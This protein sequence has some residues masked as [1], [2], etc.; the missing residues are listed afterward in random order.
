[1]KK[2]LLILFTLV[3]FSI[4]TK[5]QFGNTLILNGSNV[6]TRQTSEGG[7]WIKKLIQPPTFSDTTAANNG[8]T[9]FYAGSIIF[10][11]N[12]NGFWYR[13]ATATAWVKFASGSTT[14]TLT[15]T[16]VGFGSDVN[17]LT[18]A[19]TLRWKADSSLFKIHGWIQGENLGR[20]GYLGIYGKSNNQDGTGIELA[21]KDLRE[22]IPTDGVYQWW[23]TD[24]VDKEI[25]ELNN[26]GFLTLSPS[27]ANNWTLPGLRGTLGDVLIQDAGG[28]ANWQNAS[29]LK[30]SLQNAIDYT[31]NF[32]HDAIGNAGTF[33][34]FNG[35]GTVQPD[36]AAIALDS[37]AMVAF[38]PSG[39]TFVFNT[40]TNTIWYWSLIDNQWHQLQNGS[41]GT[42]STIYTH[43]A[44]L[45]GERT[46]DGV[47][48][49]YGLTFL[50][51]QQFQVYTTTGDIS[52]NAT[53]GNI[54]LNSSPSGAT[55]L[56]GDNLSL[57]GLANGLSING[58][59]GTD[60]QQLTSHANAPP[61]WEDAGGSGNTI[62]NHDDTVIS[63]RAIEIESN[64]VAFVKGSDTA[65]SF[66]QDQLKYQIG[67]SNASLFINADNGFA[68]LGKRDMSA[69]YLEVNTDNN[70]VTTNVKD[71][72]TESID[73]STFDGFTKINRDYADERYGASF[74][75]VD[76][77]LPNSRTVN[78]DTNSLSFINVDTFLVSSSNDIDNDGVLAL[79][80]SRDWEMSTGGGRIKIGDVRNNGNGNLMIIDDSYSGSK[81][82][83]GLSTREIKSEGEVS[84][85][86]GLRL[87]YREVTSSG[88]IS[89]TDHTINATTGT[90]SLALPLAADVVTG[91]ATGEYTITNTGAGVITLDAGAESFSTGGATLI[92]AAGTTRRIQSNG[93]S[94]W[95]VL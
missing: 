3:L 18:G 94:S 84:V 10:T 68:R 80:N 57:T 40:T 86:G 87:N 14:P 62:Y 95:I 31:N 45:E 60:G 1:M 25:M 4:L 17:E 88:S 76:G 36:Y 9:N 61:T 53:S 39:T 28:Q 49:L 32:V 6:N 42:C 91:T 66:N 51:L 37:P 69:A 70:S 35:D 44:S 59:Y 64:T 12:D 63:N 34:K 58:S 19:N 67:G 41:S 50:D 30:Y 8:Q 79:I 33:L 5:A 82:T 74:Y 11:S 81:F 47:G 78:A 77:T 46:V 85:Q 22:Y 24:A 7:L 48:G 55:V 90:Y 20:D 72:Y 16:Q 15:A 83:V 52:L 65:L 13:N 43:S 73:T 26:N 29:D 93:V 56:S 89:V 71:N 2:K 27:D 23:Y 92:V 21:G 54:Q 38:T 75:V